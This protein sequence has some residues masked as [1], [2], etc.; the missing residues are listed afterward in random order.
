MNNLSLRDTV[1]YAMAMSV[2]TICDEDTINPK[3]SNDYV[4]LY[5]DK[6]KWEE[7]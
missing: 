1:K 2:I 7:E 6:I 4:E 3:M 5:L